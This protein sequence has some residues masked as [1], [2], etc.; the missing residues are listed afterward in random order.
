V[1]AK[2]L[3]ELLKQGK[4]PLVKLTDEIWDESFG[5]KGMIARVTAAST[6]E[7]NPE[8]GWEFHL[9]YMEHKEHNI[10]LQTPNW[11]HFKDGKEGEL[12]TAIET[13]NA[14]PNDL[15]E[16]MYVD[17]KDHDVPVELITEQTPIG[18]YVVSGS[19]LSYVQWL[20]AKL[21]ELVPDAMKTWKTGL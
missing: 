1:K 13:G 14:D 10:P 3:Y 19:E 18:E 15:R 4:R 17:N 7:F 12:G 8:D 11:R 2:V 5:E 16:K 20:E 9:D 21:E 6:S